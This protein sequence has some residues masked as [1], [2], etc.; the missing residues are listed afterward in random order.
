[1][2]KKEDRRF[3]KLGSLDVNEQNQNSPGTS[4]RKTFTLKQHRTIEIDNVWNQDARQTRKLELI[5][6]RETSRSLLQDDLELDEIEDFVS[7][8]ISES[9]SVLS[10]KA[11]MGRIT[12]QVDK[13]SADDLELLTDSSF[14]DTHERS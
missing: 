7:E 8:D 14:M 6:E 10:F 12:N 1:M 5:H 9:S 4:I 2:T 13:T 3:S 11:N